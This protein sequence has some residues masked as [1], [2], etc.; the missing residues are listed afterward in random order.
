M[1]TPLY[2]DGK[3]FQWR[4][5]SG[6]NWNLRVTFVYHIYYGEFLVMVK[7]PLLRTHFR[8][9]VS[10]SVYN[11]LELW[12]NRGFYAEFTPHDRPGMVRWFTPAR[13]YIR[14]INNWRSLSR[15]LI[16]QLFNT[17]SL[18]ND[19]MWINFQF[20]FWSREHLRVVVFHLCAKFC[21]NIFIMYIQRQ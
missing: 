8:P 18:R 19:L 12:V 14:C 9:S 7:A 17:S 1:A 13:A 10:L 6:G 5:G 16:L 2:R 20:R 3:L 4:R 11:A 15:I 21:A